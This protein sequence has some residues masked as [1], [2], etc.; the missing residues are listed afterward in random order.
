MKKKQKS[1]NK[2]NVVMELNQELKKIMDPAMIKKINNRRINI[3]RMT[4][5]LRK[6]NYAKFTSQN[7]NF[8]SSEKI[9]T[10]ILLQQNEKLPINTLKSQI[11]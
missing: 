4:N 10:Q 8:E 9:N 2:F 7:T 1:T 3:V 6:N 11:M 5:A